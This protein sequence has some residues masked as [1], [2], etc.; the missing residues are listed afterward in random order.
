MFLSHPVG[1]GPAVPLI[2]RPKF[3][4]NVLVAM[5]AARRIRRFLKNAE[6][7]EW[8]FRF[9][10]RADEQSRRAPGAQAPGV[11]REERAPLAPSRPRAEPPSRASRLAVSPCA[12]ARAR[13]ALLS[14]RAHRRP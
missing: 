3:G 7:S 11:Q 1:A 5:S 4:L 2:A 14:A 12:H 13:A 8:W 6:C 10:L 9:S